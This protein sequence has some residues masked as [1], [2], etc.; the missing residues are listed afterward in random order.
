MGIVSIA[1][2]KAHLSKLVERV[3]AGEPVQITRC[4]KPV[5]QII[6]VPPPREPIDIAAFQAAAS[7]A[8][9]HTFSLRSGDAL[10]LAI[11]AHHGATLCTLDDRLADAGAPLGIATTR[12]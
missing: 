10:H 5:A 3:V 11:C 1:E 12:L 8:G 2:A 6:A 7:F 9:Q 4:G